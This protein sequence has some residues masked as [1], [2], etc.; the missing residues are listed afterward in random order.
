MQAELAAVAQELL[1]VVEP[2]F[3]YL[4]LR[5]SCTGSAASVRL[6]SGPSEQDV[7]HAPSR[8]TLT[9]IGAIRPTVFEMRINADGTF[10]AL[11]TEITVKDNSHIPP[12]Y[13]I[14]LKPRPPRPHLASSLADV[15]AAIGAPLP[16]EVHEFYASGA[17]IDDAQVYSP[18]EILLTWSFDGR[19]ADEDP[20]DWEGPVLYVGPPGAV[21]AVQLHPLWVPF[22]CNEWGDHLCID[23]AP[24]PNGRVGQVIQLAGESPM[25]YLADSVTNL[26]MP[27]EDVGSKGLE[28]HFS[29]AGRDVASLPPTLQKLSLWDAG[30]LDFGLLAHLTSLRMLNVVRGGTVRLGG[31]AHLPLERIVV[32]GDEIELPA[33]ETLTALELSGGARVELPSL[34]NLRM[35]DV[36]GVDVDVE[37]LPQVDYLVLNTGQWQ[38]CAQTPATATLAG[39]S[40]LASALDWARERGAG[41]GGEVVTGT[42]AS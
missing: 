36:S 37:S 12:T 23:L 8:E 22:A 40:S 39:E 26:V 29:V 10:H 28:D 16:A 13:T 3:D 21:R 33:C 18:D 11:V 30:D 7:P 24:G 19:M 27:D 1:A 31:L 42:A 34:P 41:L 20:W 4:T 9:P 32:A 17:K 25:R 38:R 14:V 5:A 35:L 2:G 6:T 15:E